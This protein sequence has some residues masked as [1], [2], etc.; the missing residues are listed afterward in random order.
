[1]AGFLLVVVFFLDYISQRKS[2][3]GGAEE[4]GEPVR[5]RTSMV[6]PFVRGWGNLQVFTSMN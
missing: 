1:M 6:P 4:T 2:H 3:Q 5:V